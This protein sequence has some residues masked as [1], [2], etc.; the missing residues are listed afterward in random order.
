M[1]LGRDGGA[2]FDKLGPISPRRLLD[3]G[4]A[5]FDVAGP[6]GPGPNKSRI[7]FTEEAAG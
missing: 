1:P 3:G 7:L 4:A 6:E 2:G 5:E